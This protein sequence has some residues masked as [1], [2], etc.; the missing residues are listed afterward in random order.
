MYIVQTTYM[1][2]YMY[3]LNI[4]MYMYIVHVHSTCTRSVK[5]KVPQQHGLPTLI[6]YYQ[7]GQRLPTQI[8]MLSI[9]YMWLD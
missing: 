5:S 9:P 6:I 8:V 1:Y 3:M 7:N 4:Y 2:M